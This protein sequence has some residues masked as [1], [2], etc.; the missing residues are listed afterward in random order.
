MGK[1]ESKFW[2]LTGPFAVGLHVAGNAVNAVAI[3]RTPGFSSVSIKDLTF[4]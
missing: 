2:M 3:K 1:R 4:L